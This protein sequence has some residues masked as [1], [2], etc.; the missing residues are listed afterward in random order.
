MKVNQ[1]GTLI[2]V[3]ILMASLTVTQVL[4]LSDDFQLPSPSWTPEHPLYGLE[5]FFEENFEV[6]IARLTG[7]RQGAAEKRILLAEERL[8]EM[9]V[10]ANGTNTEGLEDLRI[11]YERQMNITHALVNGSG[12]VDLDVGILKRTMYH[13]GVLT[14]VRARVPEQARQGID[15]AFS[16]STRAMGLQMRDIAREIQASGD[17]TERIEELDSL[18]AEIE[19]RIQIFQEVRSRSPSQGP[20]VDIGMPFDPRDRGAGTHRGPP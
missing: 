17:S 19:E 2:L 3:A 8:A 13:A 20:P 1:K 7:G 11:G 18:A 4:A 15:K 5:R 14:Q 16:S 10:I 12:I 6:P 9:E